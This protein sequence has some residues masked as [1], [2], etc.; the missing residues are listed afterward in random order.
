MIFRYLVQNHTARSFQKS[1]ETIPL[2]QIHAFCG[3]SP[4]WVWAGLQW[5]W[6][7]V[8]LS[9]ILKVIIPNSSSLRTELFGMIPDRTSFA[10]VRLEIKPLREIDGFVM[11]LHAA[12]DI[13]VVAGV[14][15]LEVDLV[16]V[17]LESQQFAPADGRGTGIALRLEVGH[18]FDDGLEGGGA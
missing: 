17:H 4:K 7:F 5:P 14:V 2:I 10:T 11:I 16:L 1:N 6:N 12:G 3:S 9:S 8:I 18:H 13:T 15:G